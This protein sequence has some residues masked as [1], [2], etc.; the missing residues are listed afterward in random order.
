V[1]RNISYNN[2]DIKQEIDSLV[3]KPYPVMTRIRMKGTGSPKYLITE[4]SKEIADK[5]SLD[6]NLNYC[7]IELRPGGIIIAFRSILETFGWILPFRQF[8]L[9]P[10]KNNYSIYSGDD[11]IIFENNLRFNSGDRFLEK[12]VKLQNE[13]TIIEDNN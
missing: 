3:G 11:Y 4:A 2:P 13:I 1:I 5:L 12:L 10:G 9:S 6:N 8:R 7:S